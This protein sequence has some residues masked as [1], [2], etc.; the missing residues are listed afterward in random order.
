MSRHPFDTSEQVMMIQGHVPCCVV[1]LKDMTVRVLHSP[2]PPPRGQSAY[3][4][5]E[6]SASDKARKPC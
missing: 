6:N 3:N 1:E 5:T 2:P 4:N